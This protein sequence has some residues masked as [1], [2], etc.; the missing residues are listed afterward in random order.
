MDDIRRVEAI[1]PSECDRVR[2]TLRV[3]S[4]HWRRRDARLP[5]FTLGAATYLDTRPEVET[6]Y[7]Y[8]AR[9]NPVLW[10][11]FEWLYERLVVALGQCLEG[12]LSFEHE[13][14]APGFHLYGSHPA[15]ERDIA[16][17]HFD[18]QQTRLRWPKDAVIQWSA[19]VSFTLPIALPSSGGGLHT[20]A[21]AWQ[22]F[23]E[24][25]AESRKRLVAGAERS[26]HRY[27]PGE[28]VVHSGN[29]LHQAAPGR[30]LSP[31]DERFTLQG[32]ALFCDGAWRLY[33]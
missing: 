25:D 8:V 32:H 15:F 1:T 17:I 5:F 22:E 10:G 4:E 28:L 9:E 26:L 11:H 6:Y 12:K 31:E 2:S 24:A 16:E 20:W 7:R 14:A 30:Q 13:Q 18:R 21:L 33:W 27:R 3:L 29:L 23:S 19:P